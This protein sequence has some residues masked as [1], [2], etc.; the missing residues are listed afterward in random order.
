MDTIA[1]IATPL[2]EGG[3]SVIRISGDKAVGIAEK[4]FRPVSG[5][6]VSEMKGYTAAYGEIVDGDK[7]LD[8]GVLLIF[9]AP[10]SYTG[11]DVA[12]ISCHGG[13]YIT[14]RVLSACYNAGA[15]S[16]QAGEFTKRALLNGKLSLTQAEAVAD[17]ISA[18]N[19]QYLMCSKAQREGSLYRRIRAVSEKILTLTTLIQAWIDYPDEM[20]DDFDG[21]LEVQ[22]LT[23]VIDELDLL[24]NS[25]HSGQLMREGV[26]CAIVGRPNVGKST[27][28]NLLSG[29][30]RSIVT[31]IEGTTRDIV[32]E[33][34]M[35]GNVM[36]RLADCAGIR[37]TDDVVES[38]G[39][40]RMLKKI[41]SA[42]LVFAVFDGSRQ[43]SDDDRRL[44]SHLT[45][46]NCICIINKTDLEQVIDKSELSQF[47]EI[48]EISAK[49]ISAAEKINEAVSR[50]TG[51][52]K[53]DLSSGFIAN[54]RQRI[55]IQEAKEYI[56]QALTA[57]QLGVTLDAVGIMC[58]SALER[59]YELSGE[60]VSEAV[61]D[62]VFARFCVGK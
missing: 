24:L 11:E 16:A 29:V 48:I 23:E 51:L 18:Q 3:I 50:R 27:L 56:N 7:K 55:C 26:P 41:D 30:E 43:L 38:I 31:D 39:V 60:N 8:D 15:K 32:E 36:L 20:E 25:Y 5:K 45:D 52:S 42:S 54:E 57:L 62:Q 19:E 21:N 58:E 22:K 37:D 35:A 53:L 1:A 13:L 6:A 33:T 10:H 9:R 14:K 34:V 2:A 17:I 61:I 47:D 4:I 46:K 44:M 49:D 28:M 12:E 59:L 40:E